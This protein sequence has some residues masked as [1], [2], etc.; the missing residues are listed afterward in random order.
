M[1]GVTDAPTRALFGEHGAFSYAVS[2]FVRVSVGVL[3]PKVFR[4]CVPE[5]LTGGKTPTG[6]PVQVQILGGNPDLVAETAYNAY[7]VGATCIDLNFGCPAPIVNNHDGGAALLRH[8]CRLRD[9]VSAVKAAVPIPV[10]AKLRLGWDNIEAIHENAAMAAEG[11]ASWLTIHARTKAQGYAPPVY[12][13]PIGKVRRDLGLPVIANGDIWTVDDFLRCR[14]ETGCIHYMLGRSAMA[15]P[16]LSYAVAQELGIS[17]QP[18]PSVDWVSLL[19]AH[20]RWSEH[21]GYGVPR[22]MLLRLKQWLAMASKFGDFAH[23]DALK[24]AQNI[25]EFFSQLEELVG[26]PALC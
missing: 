16:S 2:E 6:L 15:N 7:H 21:F 4:R 10:S 18:V 19:R 26:E 5:L 11:G 14:E 22:L 9:I 12:W 23:F 20:V 24:R 25:E 17:S 8:P 13:K 3:P 1:E